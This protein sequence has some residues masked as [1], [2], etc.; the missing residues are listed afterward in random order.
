MQRKEEAPGLCRLIP[1]VSDFI[2]GAWPRSAPEQRAAE[3]EQAALPLGFPEE[4]H[5]GLS[6]ET[7]FPQ[8]AW[9]VGADIFKDQAVDC[10]HTR[11]SRSVFAG[12]AVGS[13][14]PILYQ[15]ILPGFGLIQMFPLKYF[16]LS[17]RIVFDELNFSFAIFE[18]KNLNW[19]SRSWRLGPL[20]KD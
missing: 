14:L 18:S 9:Q 11:E 2:S 15:E 4:T 17:P 13:T 3:V 7:G 16:A 6:K 10:I 5:C 20:L 12:L 1:N 8:H 19:M